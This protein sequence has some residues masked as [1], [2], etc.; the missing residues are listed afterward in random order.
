MSSGCPRCPPSIRSANQLRPF[1]GVCWPSCSLPVV[2]PLPC[3]S[4]SLQ[5]RSARLFPPLARSTIGSILS[6][7]CPLGPWPWASQLGGCLSSNW[8]ART[9][10][11]RP[12]LVDPPPR[13]EDRISW[14]SQE[15]FCQ[16][17]SWSPATVRRRERATTPP[18]GSDQSELPRVTLCYP[19]CAPC[20][21]K[22]P[23][24]PPRSGRAL[25]ISRRS[26]ATS[27]TVARPAGGVHVHRADGE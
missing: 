8:R 6:D 21:S 15:V 7:R 2:R 5:I 18:G 10:L 24:C 1:F 23:M 9:R 3:P 14:P 19:W 26:D 12:H 4:Y 25:Q 16:A 13:N 20:S 11:A 27:G 22:T 17:Y